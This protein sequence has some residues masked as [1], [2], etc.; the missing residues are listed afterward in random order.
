MAMGEILGASPGNWR[1]SGSP[2]ERPNLTYLDSVPGCGAP[3]VQLLSLHPHNK[4]IVVEI[5]GVAIPKGT[6]PR[7]RSLLL[8]EYS[9]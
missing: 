5:N 1:T 8:P 3:V 7:T 4:R 6:H 9:V 2:G